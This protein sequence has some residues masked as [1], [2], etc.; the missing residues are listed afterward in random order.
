MSQRLPRSNN[1]INKLTNA[2]L[3]TYCQ[4]VHDMMLLNVVNFPTPPVTMINFQGDINNY[5]TA[6]AASIGGSKEQRNTMRLFRS[7]VRGD[8]QQLNNY[9]NQLATAALS[10]GNTYDEL[11]DLILSSGL[12]LGQQP[13]PVGPLGQPVIKKY[14]SPNPSQLYVLI[15]PKLIGAKSYVLRYG[16]TGTDESTWLTS[17]HANTRINQYGLVRGAEYTFT[18]YGRGA[19]PVSTESNPKTQVII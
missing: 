6:L 1:W 18:V 8:L 12:Q 14:S 17:V 13:A 11:N 3:A 10:L 9:V 19:N 2:N 16:I 5:N 4:N 15:S 7:L